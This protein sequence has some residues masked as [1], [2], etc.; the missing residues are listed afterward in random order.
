MITLQCFAVCPTFAIDSILVLGFWSSILKN[1]TVGTNKECFYVFVFLCFY[2]ET[3][4]LF[5]LSHAA[6]PSLFS[7]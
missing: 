2:R 3:E 4:L 1:K 5:F 6:A 7:K